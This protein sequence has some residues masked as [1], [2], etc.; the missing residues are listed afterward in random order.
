VD[1]EEEDSA[2]ADSVVDTP[3]EEEDIRTRRAVKHTNKERGLPT[4]FFVW[5]QAASDVELVSQFI[6]NHIRKEYDVGNALEDQKV[7]DF[8]KYKP[9]L[10][11]SQDQDQ[12]QRYKEDQENEK[13]F[14]AQVRVYIERKARY[15]SNKRKA[16][17]LICEQ[18]NKTLQEAEGKTKL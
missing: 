1:E 2:E 7:V 12:I 14:E 6:I 10:Q 5:A 9:S 18:C 4:T 15:E 8:D 17:T 13:I 11:F 3:R 16:F